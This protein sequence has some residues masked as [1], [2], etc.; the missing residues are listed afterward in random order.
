MLPKDIGVYLLS[1]SKSKLSF[2]LNFKIRKTIIN[3]NATAPIT[4]PAIAPPLSPPLLD[5]LP[6]GVNG[7]SLSVVSLW[8]SSLGKSES[9]IIYFCSVK[10]KFSSTSSK[11]FP[12][13]N[14]FEYIEKPFSKLGI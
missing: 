12:E 4:I 2:F 10:N 14:T 3:I 8:D 5:G 1:F 9:F 6:L 7:T 11:I 13:P